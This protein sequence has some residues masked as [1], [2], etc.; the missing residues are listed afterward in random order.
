MRVK[1]PCKI[2]DLQHLVFYERLYLKPTP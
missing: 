1:F 2:G